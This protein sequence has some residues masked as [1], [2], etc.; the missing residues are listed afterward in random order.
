MRA[1]R[2]FHTDSTKE[3]QPPEMLRQYNKGTFG[4]QHV[5]TFYFL[6]KRKKKKL[7]LLD[8]TS[9]LCVVPMS[10][11]F[12]NNFIWGVK[13]RRRRRR[14]RGNYTAKYIPVHRTVCNQYGK[15]KGWRTRIQSNDHY[16]K[17]ILHWLATLRLLMYSISGGIPLFSLWDCVVILL[18]R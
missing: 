10:N 13:R 9:W 16:P 1:V 18:P 3:F 5:V 17:T 8:M 7:L 11:K 6:K 14:R 2:S 4:N 15:G 12:P